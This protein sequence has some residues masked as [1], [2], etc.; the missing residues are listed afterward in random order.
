MIVSLK[1]KLKILFYNDKNEIENKFPLDKK[2]P[3]KRA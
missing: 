1:Q 3:F 2:N